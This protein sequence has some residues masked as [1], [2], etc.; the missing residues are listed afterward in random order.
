M[1][2]ALYY[3]IGGDDFP[4]EPRAKDFCAQYQLFYA[5]QL[6]ALSKRKLQSLKAGNLVIASFEENLAACGLALG[7][8][9]SQQ[10][11]EDLKNATVNKGLLPG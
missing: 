10:E 5:W 11:I 3:K 7:I 9:F 1:N 4:L 6:A 2:Q 8:Q